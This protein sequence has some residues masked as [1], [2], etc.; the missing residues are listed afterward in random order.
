MTETVTIICVTSICV[1]ETVT[2]IW[3]YM[4]KHIYVWP[5]L[6]SHQA[7]H[8]TLSCMITKESIIVQNQVKK[9]T[10]MKVPI[11]IYA[12]KWIFF[13]T[14]SWECETSGWLSILQEY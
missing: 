1:T 8:M 9:G 7:L 6:Q 12:S 4:G 5:S 13:L 14:Q 10:I 11:I 3:S 2:V